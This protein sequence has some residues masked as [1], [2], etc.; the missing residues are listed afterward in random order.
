MRSDRGERRAD[1]A[2]FLLLLAVIA[3]AAWLA[4]SLSHTP[5]TG[6]DDANI[7]FVYARNMAH[8]HGL[9]YN[10]GGEHVEGYTS[11]AWLMVCAVTMRI[12]DEIEPALLCVNILAITIAAYALA[13][14]LQ[15]FGARFCALPR[16]HAQPIAWSLTAAVVLAPG[17]L[18][19][20][21]ISLMDSGVWCATVLLCAICVLRTFLSEPDARRARTA[22]FVL[23]TLL[24]FVRPEA[25]VWGPVFLALAMLGA[26]STGRT[27]VESIGAYVA[28]TVAFVS[29]VG[30]QTLFRMQY[31]GYPLP[32]TY[33]AK[34]SGGVRDRIAEG[35][36]YF[37]DFIV[38]NPVFLFS[39]LMAVFVL[40]VT[41][42]TQRAH[43][44]W[45][46]GR[47][48][49]ASQVCTLILLLVSSVVPILEGGE[50][51]GLSRLYQPGVPL[52]AVQAVHSGCAL[53]APAGRLRLK[54][55]TIFH[56]V[57]VLIAAAGFTLWQ[58]LP[59]IGYPSR[60]SSSGEWSTPR[61]EMSIASD[62]RD[63][64]SSF[65]RVFPRYRPSVGVIVAGGFA[66]AYQGTVI[67]LMGL[68]SVAMGHSP[69]PRPGFKDHA[70]FDADVFFTLTPDVVLLA[71]W[72]PQRPD[73]FGFP[74]M[75]GVFDVPPDSTTD[76]WTRRALSVA[77]FDGGL[78]KGMLSQQ[79]FADEY[80]WASVRMAGGRTWVHALFHRNCLT[81]LAG[82]GYE[83]AYPRASI[84]THV[85]S[86]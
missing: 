46:D 79:R 7:F 74:M 65:N 21:T 47:R 58:V 3:A 71:L 68:N 66:L 2:L 57:V 49:V 31:F 20:T 27:P 29:A 78:F 44:D 63:V 41:I 1:V 52:V 25:M 75:S 82:L 35:V 67:D 37:V 12:T 26:W 61:V 5:L 10:V 83:I 69:G 62:M 70:A 80:G 32:N 77:A 13:R 6:Y 23:I 45:P 53:F 64:G 28:H 34:A 22:L 9:V 43:V 14:Y 81:H 17:Y 85:D 24:A 4:Q 59:G 30:A 15:A 8:G 19:W 56:G 54:G 36:V 72:S 42:R 16:A 40:A 18:V 51:F 50:H 48:L 73:W 55:L 33:Y 39:I 11:P 60:Y 84:P 76:Y 86:R 38:F